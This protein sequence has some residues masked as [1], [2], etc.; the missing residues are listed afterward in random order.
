[1][2]KTVVMTMLMAHE[3]FLL[4]QAR[5]SP[6]VVA[7]VNPG[8]HCNAVKP[9]VRFRSSSNHRNQ[10]RFG[11]RSHLRAEYAHAVGSALR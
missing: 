5:H 6:S 9:E 1:M 10:Q 11:L 8:L 3:S 7:D 2:T 4:G